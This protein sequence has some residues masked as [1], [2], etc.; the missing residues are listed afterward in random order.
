MACVGEGVHVKYIFDNLVQA[1]RRHYY[2]S[3]K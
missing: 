3:S 2:M 1:V